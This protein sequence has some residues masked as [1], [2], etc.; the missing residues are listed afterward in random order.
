M[1]SLESL[2]D[3]QTSNINLTS[4]NILREF[5][6]AARFKKIKD[7]GVIVSV[8]SVLLGALELSRLKSTDWGVTVYQ[9]TRVTVFTIYYGVYGSW[10][11][12]HQSSSRGP[13]QYLNLT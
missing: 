11:S 12:R 1:K 4:N 10:N 2:A 6:E 5:F 7:R 8:F 9:R 3:S 13:L